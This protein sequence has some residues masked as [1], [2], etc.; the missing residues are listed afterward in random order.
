MAYTQQTWSDSPATSS[1]ISAAR[2]A[3]IEQGVFDAHTIADA[4]TARLGPLTKRTVT[5]AYTLVAGDATDIVLHTTA[6]SGFTI[7][8][9]QDS[10]VSI[11]QEI[12]I[13][14]RQYGAG[15]IT[16][17]AGTGATLVSR[18]GA[19]KSAGQYAGGSLTKVAANVW[20]LE[21]DIST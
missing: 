8:L 20:L 21:G 15:Q 1:P 17:A 14:W 3:Y 2:L 5:G 13:P 18:G 12:P 6:A 19:T 10:A 16:F 11:A 7:T 9:P 4:A